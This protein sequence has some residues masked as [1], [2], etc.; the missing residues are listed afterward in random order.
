MLVN[1]Q[2]GNI[3]LHFNQVDMAWKTP[4]N[5]KPIET[6]EEYPSPGIESGYKNYWAILLLLAFAPVVSTYTSGGTSSLPGSFLCNQTD[7]GCT[8]GDSHAKAAHKY[9]IGTYNLYATQFGRDSI[10]NQR[11]DNCQQCSLL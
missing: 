1:A 7:P 10:D 6:V 11:N 5:T 8:L 4:K 9:A 2:K 3:S